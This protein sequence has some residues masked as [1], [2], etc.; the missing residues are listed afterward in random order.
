M[1]ELLSTSRIARINGI[2]PRILFDLLVS[3]NYVQKLNDTY[4]L[5]TRGM[6][7]G[8][9]YLTTDSGAR[10]IGWPR[11]FRIPSENKELITD[12]I[13]AIL[14]NL[15]AAKKTYRDF[16]YHRTAQERMTNSYL[17]NQI[18]EVKEK[19]SEL[20]NQCVT[21][22]VKCKLDLH[23]VIEYLGEK[24][25]YD[26]LNKNPYISSYKDYR[27]FNE[28][29]GAGNI[30]KDNFEEKTRELKLLF[31]TILADGLITKEEKNKLE[32]FCRQNKIDQ[33]T[34]YLIR[35]QIFTEFQ[36]QFDFDKIIRFHADVE[37]LKQ[38]EIENLLRR[39]YFLDPSAD[40]IE[41]IR[42]F[43]QQNIAGKINGE[44]VKSTAGIDNFIKQLKAQNG[45]TYNLYKVP[46]PLNTKF[47]FELGPKL[48]QNDPDRIFITEEVFE[49][50]SDSEI[51][52]IMLDAIV[53]LQLS[54]KSGP[55]DVLS[56]IDVRNF[57]ELK[58]KVRFALKSWQL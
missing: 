2:E 47:I 28:S 8:G 24:E 53:Y 56:S 14:K 48:T 20:E 19:I 36:H 40:I 45:N 23:H 27:S 33:Q 49:N 17:Q 22:I 42:I 4:V 41:R 1:S 57:L 46:G 54:K 10:F 21:Y 29:V 30:D 52:D 5:T 32:L 55:S 25:Y 3:N 12:D 13:A 7:M 44:E 9:H 31:Q 39:E 26:F 18:R 37:K 50:S 35:K 15:I 58:S 11:N 51:L 34:S 38:E 16:F 43:T 6:E